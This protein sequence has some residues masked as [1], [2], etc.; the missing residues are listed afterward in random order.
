MTFL[1]ASIPNTTYFS[2]LNT[3]LDNPTS[4]KG[5]DFVGPMALKAIERLRAETPS[6]YE[7]KLDSSF[8]LD[9]ALDEIWMECILKRI[10]NLPS[11]AIETFSTIFNEFPQKT[12][13]VKNELAFKFIRTAEKNGIDLLNLFHK[14]IRNQIK[15]FKKI[16]IEFKNEWKPLIGK[17]H[18][19]ELLKWYNKNEKE[20][21][22][23]IYKHIQISPFTRI[24]RGLEKDQ[25]DEIFKVKMK[26]FNLLSGMNQKIY[27][28]NFLLDFYRGTCKEFWKKEISKLKMSNEICS[29]D[30]SLLEAYKKKELLE[31]KQKYMKLFKKEKK[32]SQDQYIKFQFN[33]SMKDEIQENEQERKPE[34]TAVPEIK[35]DSNVK[36]LDELNVKE[37][38][39]LTQIMQFLT[40]KKKEEKKRC[41]IM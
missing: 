10:E 25:K 38:E 29:N 11:E 23:K 9:N 39:E 30:K 12:E 34:E 27:M 24:P 40:Q 20:R 21:I 41:I 4:I 8:N 16:E 2:R 33:Y 32:S 22:L 6:K 14:A 35:T 26:Y 37:L 18:C 36:E 7:I 5:I 28:N 13:E 19:E 15:L 17:I 31:V 1:L 3:Y